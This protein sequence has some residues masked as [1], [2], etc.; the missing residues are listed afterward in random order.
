MRIFSIFFAVFFGWALS[1]AGASI[2]ASASSSGVPII[3]IT[4]D[5][6]LG[7]ED[8]FNALAI[9][10]KQALVILESP[11][12]KAYPAMEI[13]RTISIKNFAT[14]VYPNGLCSSACALTWL[15]GRPRFIFATSRIGFHA[16][17]TMENGTADVSA[18]GNA[19]VGQYLQQLG[20]STGAIVFATSARPESMNWL[21]QQKAQEIGLEVKLFTEDE[22]APSVDTTNPTTTDT[23]VASVTPV[24]KPALS[25]TWQLLP[26]ADLP[27]A[28]LPGM[29]LVAF[30][31]EECKAK[32]ETWNG[33]S[34]FT[35]NEK[36]QACFLKST[37]AIALQ[38]TGA[39]SG[40]VT[41]QNSVTRMGKDH[42]QLLKFQTNLGSEI[43][44]PPAQAYRDA[45]LGWCQDKCVSTKWCQGFNF[46][47]SNE[48]R[49]L[50]SSRPTQRNANVF[51][52]AKVK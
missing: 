47:A 35:F 2:E 31:A 4:G 12:G 20:L 7:D 32:C 51:S 24:T 21:S 9:P 8:K 14:S 18:S 11:G 50:R 38:F 25:R 22:I 6:E 29:P 3:T 37:A 27:G 5:F 52:G 43:M 10:L 1:A 26:Y 28:D 15:A 40:Y 33:C 13:G 30:T 23:E 19:L 46:Y 49:L 36:H 39:T 16:L 41:P 17:F 44:G 48:C 34:A 42:G 45:S